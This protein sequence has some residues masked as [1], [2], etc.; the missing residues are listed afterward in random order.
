VDGK[1][2]AVEF[3]GHSVTSPGYEGV[4]GPDRTDAFAAAARQANPSLKYCDTH[5]RGYMSLQLSS[6]TV[7]GSWHFMQTIAE[8][9][10]TVAESH[11]M[12]VQ[13]GRRVLQNT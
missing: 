10:S 3:A 8:R 4:S 6:E 12:Q 13:R 11:T 2:A 5:R 9:N 1:P 7:S